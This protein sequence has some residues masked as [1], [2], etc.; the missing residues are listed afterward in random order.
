LAAGTVIDADGHVV[1]PDHIWRDLLPRRLWPAAPKWVVDNEGRKRRLIGGRL[2]PYIPFPPG[3]HY[4]GD[5]TAASFDPHVRATVFSRHGIRLGVVTPSAGLHFAAVPEREVQAALCRAYNDWIAAFCSETSAFRWMA[6]VP[7][8]DVCALVEEAEYAL[9]RGACGVLMRPNPIGG[10]NLDD[11]AFDPL[12]D[13]LAAADRPLLLHE[14][15]TMNVP[16]AGTDRFTNYLYLH[17]VSQ[18]HEHQMACIAL[19]CGG[20]LDRYPSLRV[21]FFEA[22]AGWV[23]YWLERMDQHIRYW[24]HASRPLPLLPSEYFRRQCFV[25]PFADEAMLPQVIQR[26]GSRNLVFTSD[27]PMPYTN[28]ERIADALLQRTDIDDESKTFIGQRNAEVLYKLA[29]P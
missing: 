26:I 11:P 7:Q 6:I 16:E 13:L 19:I 17:A 27:F 10:R 24:G 5:V 14:A 9:G 22:G 3:K 2:Q 21:A 12:W 8:A 25:S 18:P 29:V 4:D 23:P 28:T 1:E 20:V 15:T